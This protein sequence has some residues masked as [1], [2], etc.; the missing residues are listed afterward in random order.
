MGASQLAHLVL[1]QLAQRKPCVGQRILGKMVQHVALVWP[2]RCPQKLPAPGRLVP[3]APCVVPRGHVIGPISRRRFCS[4][5]NFRNRLQSMQ[6]LGVRPS[7]RHRRRAHHPPHR[8]DRAVRRRRGECQTPAHRPAS[9]TSRADP[10]V[11]PSPSPASPKPR[12]RAA[13]IVAPRR[14]NPLCKA[15]H[16][17]S[18]R[19]PR[20]R[21]HH[22]GRLGRRG[23]PLSF[24][25][26]MGRIMA[27]HGA[28]PPPAC[29]RP[30]RR[31][32]LPLSSLAGETALSTRATANRAKLEPCRGTAPRSEPKAYGRLVDA[33]EG[34]CPTL[35]TCPS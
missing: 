8:S 18:Y 22:A 7:D 27:R 5:S 10:H 14:Q 11:D 31:L 28:L 26:V 4:A 1:R 17:Q 33:V 20:H 29:S 30:R 9:S 24:P 35:R 6:G 23:P 16:T 34:A 21:R 25:K 15:A 2:G 3:T 13:F 32:P 12:R 19:R